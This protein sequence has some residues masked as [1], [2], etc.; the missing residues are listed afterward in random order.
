MLATPP[1]RGKSVRVISDSFWNRIE[2]LLPKHRN[3]HRFGGGRPR[4]PD[5]DVMNAIFFVL[6][7][8]CQWAALDH[9]KFCRHSTAHARFQA[10]VRLGVFK[11]MWQAGLQEWDD[12]SGVDWSWLSLD[13]SMTKAPLG[14][15]KGRPKPNRSRKMRHETQ[16]PDRRRGS[17]D[18]DR[19]RRR[20]L[21]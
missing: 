6:R 12:T 17:S 11:R 20:K 15:E 21:P 14:G 3:T 10:W 4:V 5:R 1:A 7:T 13:G 9:T 19:D 18:S 2:S 16:H 8:G